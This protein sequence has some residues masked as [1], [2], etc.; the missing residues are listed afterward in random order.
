LR[1]VLKQAREQREKEARPAVFKVRVQNPKPQK[2][3]IKQQIASGKA[4]L[5]RERAA[6]PRRAAV[7]SKNELEV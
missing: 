3:S 7:K 6:A 1:D 4:Q 5:A 2:P